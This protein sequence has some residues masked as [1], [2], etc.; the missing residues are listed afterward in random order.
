MKYIS[1]NWTLALKFSIGK[2]KRMRECRILMAYD[3][4]FILNSKCINI[5]YLLLE[6]SRDM[7]AK[8]I[9][10][11]LYMYPGTCFSKIQIW[12]KSAVN[13]ILNVLY[14]DLISGLCR[15]IFP[16]SLV[17]PIGLPAY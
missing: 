7:S 17:S 14:L 2:K 9:C 5:I 10:T 13:P 11:Y 6:L 4:S 1:L 16:M 8:F 15:A 3:C 12:P